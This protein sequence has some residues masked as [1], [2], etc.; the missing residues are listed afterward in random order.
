MARPDG[1]DR[2]RCPRDP[3][4]HRP[5]R[6]RR[7]RRPAR[8][9][10]HLSLGGG[11]DPT[12]LDL[13]CR[14]G[15]D[16]APAATSRPTCSTRASSSKGPARRRAIGPIE[17]IDPTWIS[18]RR[19]RP[20]RAPSTPSPAAG[21]TSSKRSSA[22]CRREEKPWI[23][24]LA[25]QVVRFCRRADR[26]SGR[27]C[28]PGR[29]GRPHGVDLPGRATLER[30]TS[31]SGRTTPEGR[32]MAKHS[33]A[34]RERRTAQSARVAEIEA[35]WMGSVPT[36]TAK[37]FT[38]SVEAARARGPSPADRTWRPARSRTRLARVASRAGQ[39]RPASPRP[40][41]LTR[42][43]T[44]PSAASGRAPSFEPERPPGRAARRLDEFDQHAVT[45]AGVD[46]G[47]G[48]FR[49]AARRRVDELQ[50]VDLEAEQRLGEVRHL[51][52]D[53]VEALALRLEEAGDAGRVVG[54]LD[55]LDLRL[56]DRRGTRCA[57][58]R[59][60]M[61]MT[62]SSSRPSASRQNP[63]VASIEATTSAT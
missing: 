23:R 21:S 24:D 44:D 46:E 8:F 57:P 50:P 41:R 51:E 42:S 40:P 49:T 38:L 58:G 55:Q 4:G 56:A 39:G 47:H 52:A 59:C 45:G 35:A 6:P 53:V 13:F 12:W 48:P 7:L 14:G 22:C 61:S 37:A 43:A 36:A 31:P 60:G 20:R 28:S 16:R 1:P 25:G 34:E 32:I 30:V 63:S 17:R 5:R 33:K 29:C 26:A 9:D 54:R 2:R 62:V 15:A 11:L 19:P 18:A 10:A 27:R 3:P